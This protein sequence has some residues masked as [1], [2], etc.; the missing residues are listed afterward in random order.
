MHS[1]TS[2]S[3]DVF[4][5]FEALFDRA[6]VGLAIWDRGLRCV[7]VNTAFATLSGADAQAHVGRSPRETLGAGGR[8]IERLLREAFAGRDPTVAIEV[9]LAAS[10]QTEHV[11]VRVTCYPVGGREG[12]LSAAVTIMT[13]LGQAVVGAALHESEERFRLLVDGVT[14]YAILMLDADGRVVSWNKGAERITGYDAREI[15]GQHVSRFHAD[16]S[17]ERREAAE[18][19]RIAAAQGRVATEN[20]RVRK[21]GQ[22]FW[23]SAIITALRSPEGDLRGFAKVVRDLTEQ[24]E[25]EDALR[26]SENT[27]RSL[28]QS[29]SDGVIVVDSNARV[30][31]ANARAEEMFGYGADELIGEPIEILVPDRLRDV[32][33]GYRNDFITAPRARPM[34]RGLDLTARR[35]NGSEFPVE[36]GLGTAHVSETDGPLVTAV[37][38]DIT[39]RKQAEE[40]LAYQAT[41]DSLTGLPNRALFH[42]RLQQVLTRTT[43][44]GGSDDLVAVLFFDLDRFKVINDSLG[45]EAGD[46]VLRTVA[47]RLLEIVR[48]SDTVARFGGDEFAMLCDGLTGPRDAARIAERILGCL[49]PPMENPHGEQAVSASIGIA[50]ADHPLSDANSL[51]R[52]ADAAMY[53]AK[54]RGKGRFELFDA[55]LRQQA[56][57][58]LEIENG[59]RRAIDQ[60]EFCLVYQPIVATAT[61]TIMGVEALVRWR[62]PTR[63]LLAPDQFIPVAEETG[64]IVPLGAWVVQEACR[65]AARWHDNTGETPRLQMSVNVSARQLADPDIK[66]TIREALEAEGLEPERL[67]LEITETELMTDPRTSVSALEDLGGLGVCFAVDDFG[68]GYSS[69]SRLREFPVN[70]LKIDRSFIDGLGRESADYAI[71][72]AVIGLARSYGI[73]AVAEGVEVH[74]QEATLSELG[75]DYAQGYLY[76]RPAPAARIETL[77]GAS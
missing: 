57:D 44:Q 27:L 17:S 52:D 3:L 31:S 6:P 8:R 5:L 65:Q 40:Q 10:R 59:L 21:D 28:L 54:R 34:G 26:V 50:I 61:R 41:H 25:A 23:A 32:H 43:R 33:R 71:V 4:A 51:L 75:C 56:T 1:A 2:P 68:T 47:Q 64:L 14:D 37:V 69:L 76:S 39:Q 67:Q 74:E 35:K 19:L 30:V 18:L 22:R 7:A 62:H 9:P 55:Q 36:V 42:D 15:I 16:G 29:A 12:D 58:R 20:W 13:D 11:H 53:L 24:R 63:G 60:N 38:T 73:T 72:D 49:A 77:L 70:A 45:H 46:E 66:C 48:P